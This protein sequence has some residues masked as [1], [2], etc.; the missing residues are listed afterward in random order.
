MSSNRIRLSVTLVRACASLVAIVIAAAP[1]VGVT[2][3]DFNNTVIFDP[4]TGSISS[5]TVDGNEQVAAGEIGYF[6]R[7]G[8]AG[9]ES[10]LGTDGGLNLLSVNQN[11]SDP[12][13]AIIRYELPG[14]MAFYV[15]I[16]VF[17]LLPVSGVAS[18]TAEV[19]LT[20]LSGQPISGSIFEYNDLNLTGGTAAGAQFDDVAT[21]F[22]A[23]GNTINTSDALTLTQ[24]IVTAGNS[25]ILGPTAYEIGESA[26]LLAALTDGSPTTLN[27]TSSAATDVAYAL[28][29]DFG[30]AAEGTNPPFEQYFVNSLRS[31]NSSAEPGREIPEPTTAAVVLMSLG[32]IALRVAQRR[33]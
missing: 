7:L 22:G 27:S 18:L 31:F 12:S 19:R 9:G 8:N 17:V 26:S 28:Q 16:S 30:L 6:Y 13:F 24:E 15:Y 14:V 21:L 2:L 33:R 20:S 32:V 4:D 25:A 29:F 23:L 3:S 11:A 1:A 10:R 5:W